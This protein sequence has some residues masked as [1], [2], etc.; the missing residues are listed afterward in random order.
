MCI[1]DS[2]VCVLIP[3]GLQCAS[4]SFIRT[5]Q[6][7]PQ[8]IGDFSD[9]YVDDLAI[10]S[11]DLTDRM[12]NA[13][14]FLT[15]MRDSGLTLKLE[16]C[17]FAMTTVTFVGHCIGSGR[18]G[19]GPSKVAC[20]VSMKTLVSKKEVRQVLGLFSYFR[21][22]ID[23]FVEIAKPLTTLTRKQVPNKIHWTDVHQ[24]GFVLL[25][26]KLREATK[27][28]VINY[29]Q[30]RGILVD[31]STVAVGCCL[32]QL[33]DDGQ[34]KAIAFASAKLS[35]T[36]MAWSTIESEAYAVIFTL[37]KIRNFI[38]SAKIWIYCD[39]NPLK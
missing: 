13:R 27:Y 21:T 17:K 9:S 15:V 33:T 32:V 28:H 16:K 22:Y 34:E 38:F 7:I 37:R 1:R 39:H 24:H 23:K 2:I 6:K 35:H 30:Q 25:K 29:G 8:L 12:N 4:N 26:K 10:S 20:V 36:Q 14:S 5:V 18:H 31:A 11:D 3:F 19:P